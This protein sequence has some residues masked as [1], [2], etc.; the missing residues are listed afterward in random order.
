MQWLV[1]V[2]L[3]AIIYYFFVRKSSNLN[4]GGKN[5]K[6]DKKSIEEMCFE[7]KKCGTFVSSSESVIKNGEYYCS[8][9][10]ANLR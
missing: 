10:C 9:E 3:I 1:V 5:S 6:S 2:V 7:C 4:I 8:K